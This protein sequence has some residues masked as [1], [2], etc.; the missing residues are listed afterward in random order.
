MKKHIFLSFLIFFVCIKLFAQKQKEIIHYNIV[1]VPDLSNRLDKGMYPKAVN[2]VDLVE[3]VLKK[4]WPDIL[5]LKR[6]Q[7]Q[8]DHYRIDFLNKGLI[9]IYNI[10]TNVLN[11]DFQIF[12]KQINRINYIMSRN[13]VTNSLPKDIN[14]FIY[15]Y[16]KFNNKAA[17]SNNGA[18]I[19]TYFQSGIDNRVVLPEI[20]EG[21]ITHKFR[22]ILVL[23]TDGYIEAGIYNNGYDL[24]A[25]K[26]SDFRKAFLKSNEKSMQSFLSKNTKFKIRPANNSFLNN[27]EVIVIEMYD[28]SLSKTG[29]ATKHPTDMEIMKTI[30][31]DWLEKS[32]V[33]RFELKPISINR[34][35]GV[36][37]VLDFIKN[38]S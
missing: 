3:G 38:G 22:N 14:N 32:G 26:I 30:W 28:R 5:R 17:K 20:K 19:W 6:D 11:I 37:Y 29:A 35:E 27:L 18:D 34:V 25:S 33:K 36:K 24:S 2:D 1:F 31:T 23:M 8:K 4:I 15:E 9:G 12:D 16:R 21:L 13:S 10:N 7:G